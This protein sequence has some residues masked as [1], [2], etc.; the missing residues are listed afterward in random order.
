MQFNHSN[1]FFLALLISTLWYQELGKNQKRDASPC[2]SSKQ[3]VDETIFSRIVAANSAKEAWDTLKTEYP[4]SAKVITVKLQIL[5]RDFE[6]AVIKSN[7]TVQTYIARV[8]ALLAK[9]LRSLSCKFDHVVAAIQESKDL[10]TYSGKQAKFSY[11]RSRGRGGF[12]GR[13]RGRANNIQCNNCK[14]YGH[15]EDDCWSKDTRAQYAATT[16]DDDYLFM[17][18]LN[19]QNVDET[20]KSQVRLGD[21]K[22]VQVEGNGTVVVTLQGRE[23]FIPDVHY[24]PGLAHN[25]LSVGQL[26]DRGFDV[27][28]N[29]KNKTC[30]VIKDGE[31][32]KLLDSSRS[33]KPWSSRWQDVF[34]K[35][36]WQDVFGKMFGHSRLADVLSMLRWP[37]CI[38]QVSMD[39]CIW[40]DVFVKSRWQDVLV[41]E[42]ASL[43]TD[44]AAAIENAGGEN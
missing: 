8:S 24:G 16:E 11:N 18:Y 4:G 33:L 37:R 43:K 34:V 39:R 27:F 42:M 38:C 14:K 20:L 23:R 6:S 15:I 10:S 12:R 17:T 28:F 22:E 31:V 35:S 41:V 13:G 2:S 40:Q 26:M 30:T 44:R 1:L 3:S 25:L 21:D 7:E 5:R 29:R 36:R 32:M 19:P 9:I